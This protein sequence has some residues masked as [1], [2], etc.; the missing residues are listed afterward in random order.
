MRYGDESRSGRRLTCPQAVTAG[1]RRLG[2]DP[3]ALVEGMRG[4]ALGSFDLTIR[5][6]RV[7][8]P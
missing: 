6:G 4:R 1:L 8:H 2:D 3:R 7:R 5:G